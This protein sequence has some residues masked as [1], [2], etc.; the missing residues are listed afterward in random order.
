MTNE[1]LRAIIG[2]N[3]RNLRLERGLSIDELASLIGKTS[4]FVGLIERGD[5]G[6]TARTL[7]LLADVFGVSTDVFFYQKK[8][9]GA[10]NP[11]S[12]DNQI[13]IERKKIQSLISDFALKD[14][15]FVTNIIKSYRDA[16]F[17]A[18]VA[19]VNDEV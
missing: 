6:A 17:S 7:F 19:D 14:L 12:S 2:I 3:V 5:R 4:G 8:D 11:A 13:E 10:G 15:K 9:I 1:R 18:D 16:I